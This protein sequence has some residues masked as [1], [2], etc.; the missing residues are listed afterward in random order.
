M[1]NLVLNYFS[2]SREKIAEAL[3]ETNY[4]LTETL[5]KLIETPITVCAPKQKTMS[6]D[7]L[8]FKAT[9]DQ[10]DALDKSIRNGFTSQDQSESSGPFDLQILPEEMV[11]QNN[12][13][14]E[15]LVPVLQSVV[16][17]QETVYQSPSEYSSDLQLHDQK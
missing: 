3:K 15:C 5:V 4:D 2:G 17:K 13:F 14:Q 1:I 6:D 10:L 16:Q 8:F 9:R 12:C 11:Q 7:Q